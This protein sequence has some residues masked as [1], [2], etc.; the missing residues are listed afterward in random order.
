MARPRRAAAPTP[1]DAVAPG[2]ASPLWL[3]DELAADQ[4]VRLMAAYYAPRVDLHHPA[5]AP[6]LAWRAREARAALTPAERVALDEE[7][8][9]FAR[10][11]MAMDLAPV[12]GPALVRGRPPERAAAEQS[13]MEAVR[14]AAAAGCAARFD[15]GV[16]AGV[17]QELW[18]EPCAAWIEVPRAVEGAPCVALTVRGDSMQP[19]LHDGDTILIRFGAP[20]TVGDTI[21]A[22]RPDDGYVV[23][24]VASIGAQEIVLESLNAG[25][26][27]VRIPNDESLVVGTVVLRWCAHA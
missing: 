14:A 4:L 2:T 25:Y 13:G 6:Y 8:R 5:Q 12:D 19:M 23:K 27:D 17:G 22:R 10:R 9:A 20:P 7:A 26:A 15:L 3:D 11:V 1:D 16:A 18:D 21:V 24:R